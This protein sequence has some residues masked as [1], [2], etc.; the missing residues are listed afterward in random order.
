MK[1][2]WLDQLDDADAKVL[3]AAL[4]ASF[5]DNHAPLDNLAPEHYTR[6]EVLAVE[7]NDKL[8][9]KRK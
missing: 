8:S 4:W 6:G 9:K 7:L 1:T 3:L 2:K 5:H